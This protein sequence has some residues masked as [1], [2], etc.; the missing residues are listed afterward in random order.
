MDRRVWLPR[1]AGGGRLWNQYLFIVTPLIKQQ[2]NQQQ[3]LSLSQL[4]QQIENNMTNND[5]HIDNIINDNKNDQWTTKN[6]NNRYF[7]K[8]AFEIY[9]NKKYNYNN[10][11]GFQQMSSLK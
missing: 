4:Q 2:R 8:K 9:L 5:E 3:Q 11:H 6:L 1:S 7:V 10:V